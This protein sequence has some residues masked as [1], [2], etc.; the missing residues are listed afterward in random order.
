MQITRIIVFSILSGYLL[1][2]NI[3]KAE[4]KYSP[5]YIITN[6]NDTVRGYL[7]QLNINS[8]T[9]CNFR[10]SLN[11]QII[12]HLPGTISAYRYERDGKFYVSKEAPLETGNKVV[13][14]E[15][16]IK[17]KANIYFMRDN[18]DRYFIETDSNKIMELSQNPKLIHDDEGNLYY[19]REGFR[20]K[21][22]FML[23]DCPEIEPEI[24]KTDLQPANMIKLAKDYHNRVCNTEQC[25]IF[26]RKIKPVKVNVS[27][28]GGP[29]LN[30]F[31][32][33]NKYTDYSTG[34]TLGLK[35]E[36][37][38][39]LF[40]W[41]QTT[42]QVGVLLQN[43]S[44]F[45]V[46]YSGDIYTGYSIPKDLSYTV[47]LNIFALNIPVTCN[48]TFNFGKIRSYIGIGVANVFASSNNRS[49][50]YTIGN[51][52]KT[53]PFY[54]CGYIGMIG[55]KYRLKNNHDVIAEFSY[56][57]NQEFYQIDP[58]FNLKNK[59]LSFIVGYTL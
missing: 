17:G 35:F 36:F 52:K 13:F 23:S 42:F 21:L 24:N 53:F 26:E 32:I 22:R 31:E 33:T 55:A 58:Y 4:D 48:Y 37:E 18:M 11:D 27:I 49:F 8:Y 38:N 20:G 28:V 29:S 43:Y 14:L 1:T 12:E 2:F 30:R 59:N 25:I 5:G 50:S 15:Y 47:N 56:N 7:Q 57:A 16:L 45:H 6:A 39:L 51:D 46:R 41:E 3:A 40:S 19:K 9:K 10:K 34:G 44:A 54:R